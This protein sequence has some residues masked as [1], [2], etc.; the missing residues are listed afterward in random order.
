MAEEAAHPGVGVQPEDADGRR[1]H[2]DGEGGDGLAVEGRR[3]LLL[4]RCLTHG[5]KRSADVA[6]ATS[7]RRTQRRTQNAETPVSARPMSSFWIWLV[8]S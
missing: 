5:D 2:G 4:D 7:V 1:R 6:R 8:P 3:A